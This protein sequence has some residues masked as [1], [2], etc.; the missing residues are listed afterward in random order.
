MNERR[1]SVPAIS[2]M[3]FSTR[4]FDSLTPLTPN[5]QIL[6]PTNIAFSLETHCCRRHTCTCATKVLHHF[7]AGCYLPKTTFRTKIGGGWARAAYKKV[8]TP[9][10]FLQRMKLTASNLLHCL[11]LGLA[12]QKQC[13]GPKLA[14][15]WASG[16]SKKLGHPTYFCSR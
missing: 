1:K 2:N 6:L 3:T 11:D 16:A 9:Y 5:F 15:V 7:G 12:Y 13:L 14:G 10:V 4:N 8:G